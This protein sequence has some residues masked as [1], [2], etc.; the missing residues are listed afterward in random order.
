MENDVATILRYA[1]LLTRSVL[2]IQRGSF[3][4]RPNS[5]PG[6]LSACWPGGMEREQRPPR[7]AVAA[8]EFCL[9]RSSTGLQR[10]AGEKT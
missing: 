8:I 9:A 3:L 7:R 6:R 4:E 2:F 10:R 5:V 1:I